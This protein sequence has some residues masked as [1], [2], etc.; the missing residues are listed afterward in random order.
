M[1]V[2]NWTV[3]VDEARTVIDAAKVH[4]DEIDQLEADCSLKI[5]QAMTAVD[6]FEIGEALAST[7]ELHLGVMISSAEAAGDNVCAKM[8][9][10]INAYVGGDQ[11]MAEDAQRSAAAVPDADPEADHVVPIMTAVD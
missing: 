5:E 8:H 1:A 11:Q 2:E 7:Y 6:N 10:A 4:F 3:Q 9:E